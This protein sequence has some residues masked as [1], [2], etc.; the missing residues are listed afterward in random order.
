MYLWS[1]NT[2]G[3]FACFSYSGSTVYLSSACICTACQHI[4]WES[5]HR[6]VQRDITRNSLKKGRGRK[7]TAR[8]IVI[9]NARKDVSQSSFQK[10]WRTKVAAGVILNQHKGVI[11]SEFP[12]DVEDKGRTWSN[13]KSTQG[14][15][16]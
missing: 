6:C 10:T 3:G 16:N 4:Y 1:V 8:A 15:Y 7:I 11:I 14:S 12:K 9:H 5:S 13:P 2:R